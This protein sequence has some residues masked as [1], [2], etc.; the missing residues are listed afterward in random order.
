M[1]TSILFYAVLAVGLAMIVST[2]AFA[3]S[4]PNRPFARPRPGVAPQTP[5]FK[6]A[7]AAQRPPIGGNGGVVQAAPD[8]IINAQ[9]V[10]GAISDNGLN[11]V[12]PVSIRVKNVGSVKSSFFTVGARHAQ[13]GVA[14]AP[15]NTYT[16]LA[17]F[18]NAGG[19]TINVQELN[20]GQEITLYGYIHVPST[21]SGQTLRLRG[22][23]DVGG[24][25]E[26]AQ[27]WGSVHEMSESNNFGAEMSIP[28]P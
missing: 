23:A 18:L 3:Q 15:L 12:I 1:K 5:A 27:P 13:P 7:P 6:V 22:K 20:P 25:I 10:T 8:L 17:K 16:G 19:N 28:L 21:M 2:T 14:G 9:S 26:H 4:A 11:F 24:S